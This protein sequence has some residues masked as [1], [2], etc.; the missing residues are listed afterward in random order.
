MV[1]PAPTSASGSRSLASLLMKDTTAA[2]P[3]NTMVERVKPKNNGGSGGQKS[4]HHFSSSVTKEMNT[5]LGFGS[6]SGSGL[7]SGAPEGRGQK[8]GGPFATEKTS[9]ELF[10][11]FQGLDKQL[12]HCMAE[13]TSLQE[14][15]E[16]SVLAYPPTHL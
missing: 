3:T 11:E 12:T 15:N 5:P 4:L 9:K 1:N 2:D 6:G 10:Q 8:V 16:K 7:G 14:E 13:K